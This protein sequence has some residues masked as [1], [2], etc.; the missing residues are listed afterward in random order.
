MRKL[1]TAAVVAAVAAF[2]TVSAKAAEFTMVTGV[3][4]GFSIFYV[5]HLGGFTKKNGL[6]TELKTGPSGGASVPL[7]IGHQSNASM[8]QRLPASTTIWSTTTSAPWRRSSLSTDGTA[9]WRRTRSRR[10][11]I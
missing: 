2:G 11:K 3:D 8:R 7:L 5:G 6:D 10:S 1:L 9:S 4:P